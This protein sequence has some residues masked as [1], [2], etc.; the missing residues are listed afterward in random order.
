MKRIAAIALTACL[1]APAMAGDDGAELYRSYCVQCH[2]SAGDGKGINAPHMSVAPRDHSDPTEMSGRSDEELFK[3]IKHGGK[4]INQ[5]VLMPAWGHT[6]DD[7]Q[8]H[9]LVGHLRRLCC[10]G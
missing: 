10:G 2:G 7:E 1:V 8:I 4:S 3:V 9:A 6:L 5:S